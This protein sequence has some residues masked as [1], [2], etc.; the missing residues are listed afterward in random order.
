MLIETNGEY[1]DEKATNSTEAYNAVFNLSTHSHDGT[2]NDR[3]S[4]CRVMRQVKNPAHTHAETLG[5]C[6]DAGIM[7]T[8]TNSNGVQRQCSM[9]ARGIMEIVLGELFHVF[10]ANM[11]DKWVNMPEFMIV[12]Y[13]WASQK[14]SSLRELMS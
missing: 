7:P 1:F 3:F 11:K 6:H 5:S 4:L 13:M 10:N 8:E 2:S 14:S 9:T 12:A